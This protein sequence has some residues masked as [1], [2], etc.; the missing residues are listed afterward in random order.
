MIMIILFFLFIFTSLC[1]GVV[2]SIIKFGWHELMDPFLII[3]NK[4]KYSSIE[5]IADGYSFIIIYFLAITNFHIIITAMLYHYIILNLR[6]YYN[7]FRFIDPY[8]LGQKLGFFATHAI[9][10]FRPVYD[11]ILYSMLPKDKPEFIIKQLRKN[12]CM[13]QTNKLIP[14]RTYK[15]KNNKTQLNLGYYDDLI[16][17]EKE[18]PLPTKKINDKINHKFHQLSV[19]VDDLIVNKMTGCYK[20]ETQGKT[21]YYCILPT[22]YLD[23]ID[24][25]NFLK[26]L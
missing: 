10:L 20:C 23:V 25:I 6:K 8:Y 13:I 5:T 19:Y 12:K 7:G 2:S 9:M 15:I 4:E 1:L 18:I 3:S 11:I 22:F 14:G 26:N 17:I 21:K 24:T 16:F